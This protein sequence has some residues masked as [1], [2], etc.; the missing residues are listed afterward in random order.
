MSAPSRFF[1]FSLGLAA[2][3]LAPALTLI[4]TGCA[5]DPS[6]P[7]LAPRPVEDE[8]LAEPTLPAPPP[9]T[10]G[11]V[12]AAE[13]APAVEKARAADTRFRATLAETRAAITAGRGAATGSDA[14]LAAQTALSRVEAAREPVATV[15][16]DLD[17]ARNGD[18]ARADSGKAAA[19]ARAFEAVQAIDAAER[20]AMATALPRE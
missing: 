19:L 5:G 12:A 14:W 18:A 11:D 7:S 8:S 10:P 6:F 4:A 15:L 1:P 16:A 2:R 3:V 13:Y 9:G 20:R 17:A